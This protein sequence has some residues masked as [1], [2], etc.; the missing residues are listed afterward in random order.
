[1]DEASKSASQQ[2]LFWLLNNAADGETGK[3]DVSS[4]RCEKSDSNVVSRKVRRPGS[5][6]STAQWNCEL[7]YPT[8]SQRHWA[9][10]DGSTST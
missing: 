7:G 9:F 8:I 1:V 2:I 5:I 6:L 3:M 4:T 10:V